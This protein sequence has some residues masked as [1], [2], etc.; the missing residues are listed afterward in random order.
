MDDTLIYNGRNLVGTLT[1]EELED[2]RDLQIFLIKRFLPKIYDPDYVL[3]EGVYG[4]SEK[5]YFSNTFGPKDLVD[6]ADYWMYD[7]DVSPSKVKSRFR[8]L[9]F[10][11][12]TRQGISISITPR[13][14]PSEGF[15]LYRSLFDLEAE[16]KIK[17]A[18]EARERK[19]KEYERRRSIVAKEGDELRFYIIQNINSVRHTINAKRREGLMPAI[20]YDDFISIKEESSEKLAAYYY[21]TYIMCRD[22]HMETVPDIDYLGLSHDNISINSLKKVF[23]RAIWE[24][25]ERYEIA[26][27]PWVVDLWNRGD[28]T[29]DTINYLYAKLNGFIWSDLHYHLLGPG[30]LEEDSE[31][32]V[33]GLRKIVGLVYL[34]VVDH[35]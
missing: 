21:D 2:D 33:L 20:G 18:K 1:L 7:Q 12:F 8:G 26:E 5:D 29:T 17:E 25:A 13:R 32:L 3:G 9:N 19:I 16:R 34:T 10:V 15:E 22:T 11:C 24:D 35:D 28:D 27:V 31:K 14:T 4:L 23:E 30:Y 6:K